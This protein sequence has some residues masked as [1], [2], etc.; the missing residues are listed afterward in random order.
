L[1]VLAIWIL[2]LLL[3]RCRMKWGIF[4]AAR[5]HA[6]PIRRPRSSLNSGGLFLCHLP[7]LVLGRLRQYPRMS[8]EAQTLPL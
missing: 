7:Q 8:V 3:R 1:N 2:L 6:G 4:L 5:I